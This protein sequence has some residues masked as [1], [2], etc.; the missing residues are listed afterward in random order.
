[1]PLRNPPPRRVL[2]FPV[3]VVPP[4]TT[5]SR[6]PTCAPASS[7]RF[8]M[9]K[10]KDGQPYWRLRNPP[11]PLTD[12]EINDFVVAVDRA[13][14]GC[15]SRLGPRLARIVKVAERARLPDSTVPGEFLDDLSYLRKLG[16]L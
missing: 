12:T 14:A 16:I 13:R 2:R 7:G 11:R 8:F 9:P 6:D 3:P 10:L 1:M 15:A 5:T 4:F